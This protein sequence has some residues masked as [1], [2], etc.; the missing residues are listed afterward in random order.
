MLSSSRLPGSGDVLTA[1]AG[2]NRKP[3]DE[4]KRI[5]ARILLLLVLFA[6]LAPAVAAAKTRSPA[7]KPP[8]LGKVRSLTAP[9]P[10]ATRSA[11]VAGPAAAQ[12]AGT[13]AAPA[14][15]THR[16]APEPA[17]SIAAD[18][19]TLTGTL[20][21]P[22]RNPAAPPADTLLLPDRNP[23]HVG[24]DDTA[25]GAAVPL[26][27][28]QADVATAA[29]GVPL[30]D[31]NP[32][33]PALLAPPS[34]PV[35]PSA[36]PA[37]QVVTDMPPPDPNPNRAAALPF[38]MKGT[39]TPA[40][41]APPPAMDYASILKPILSYDLSTRTTPMSGR[42]CAA[43]RG[44]R[45]EDQGS[46]GARFRALVQISQQPGDLGKCRGHRAVPARPSRLAGAGRAAREGR[47]RALPHRCKS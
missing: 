1:D 7:A 9:C 8:A 19:T 43:G 10:T 14:P 23:T 33:P 18:A 13:E 45:G 30:P 31:R 16:A 12:A 2:R 37:P 3:T 20:P 25:C 29:F 36:A 47:D 27:S 40:I 6:C 24:A 4:M 42:C 26:A 32:K 15:K 44:G 5:R 39:L 22:D 28:P 34:L 46:C 11:A 17:P 38:A 35:A 21:L 41:A